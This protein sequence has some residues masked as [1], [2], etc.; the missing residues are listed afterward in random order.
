MR[1]VI[2]A[3]SLL[4]A[5]PPPD[6]GTADADAAALAEVCGP[7]ASWFCET[8]W[9][10]T[11]NASLSKAVDWIVTRPLVAL[12]IIIIAA[13]MS[14]WLRKGVTAGITRFTAPPTI[15]AEALERIGVMSAPDP[16]DTT[17]TETLCAVARATISAF[18]WTIATLLVLGVFNINLGPL[19]AGAGIAGIAVGFGAQSLVKDCIAGFFML[20]EDQCGVGDEID[21]AVVAGTVESLTLRATTIRA[22]DGTLWNVPNGSILRVGNQS[23]NW[24]QANVDIILGHE[25]DLDHVTEVARAA[26]TEA[27]ARP[28]VADVLLREPQVLGVE[29]LDKDGAVVRVTV[30]TKPGEQGPAARKVRLAIKQAL[31]AEGIEYHPPSAPG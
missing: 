14:R 31:A 4:S 16:R 21:I 8:T 20:L 23:R 10:A 27:A 13:L 26:A 25:A 7:R 19:L 18:V 11:Q 22:A 17:R 9:N 12:L 2:V 29:A 3:L 6:G 30:R 28:D 1:G 15:A 24:G 5:A